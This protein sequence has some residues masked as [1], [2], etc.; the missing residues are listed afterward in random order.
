MLCAGILIGLVNEYWWVNIF[1]SL[2][3][4][5][6]YCLYIRLFEPE[7]KT[8]DVLAKKISNVKL[9]MNMKPGTAFYVA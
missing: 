4:G 6:T 3:W 8:L 7:R 2:G 9:K 5:V 1:S